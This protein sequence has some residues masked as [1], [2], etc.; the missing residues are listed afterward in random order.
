M[1]KKVEIVDTR[2]NH[3]SE[4]PASL[5]SASGLTLEQ[6]RWAAPVLASVV[7]RAIAHHGE[8]ASVA[9]TADDMDYLAARLYP[10][11]E[12]GGYYAALTVTPDLRYELDA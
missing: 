7:H 10:L 1:F 11:A 3:L 8:H 6:V 9:D 12:V 4:I 5:S 2:W